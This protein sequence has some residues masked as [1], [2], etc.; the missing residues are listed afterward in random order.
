M[1]RRDLDSRLKAQ[2]DAVKL[3]RQPK[4]A[5]KTKEPLP[6]LLPEELLAMEPVARPPTPPLSIEK[7]I[8]VKKTQMPA[9]EPKPLRDIRRGGKVIRIL[10]VETGALPP[11]SSAASKAIREKWLMG[12]RGSLGGVGVPRRKMG[13]GFI[14]K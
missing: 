8:V 14:R 7:K 4:S 10:Q 5:K 12:Q 2:A 3:R 1:K 13:L 11:K 9:S 6:D